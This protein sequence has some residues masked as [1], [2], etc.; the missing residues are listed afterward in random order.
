MQTVGHTALPVNMRQ[1]LT[2]ETVLEI[3]DIGTCGRA[4]LAILEIFTTPPHRTDTCCRGILD[5]A[6]TACR[7]GDTSLVSA[8]CE[9]LAEAFERCP[10]PLLTHL[11]PHLLDISTLAL[12]PPEP[13]AG[14]SHWQQA[15]I[16][17][18][19]VYVQSCADSVVR[20]GRSHLLG[21]LFAV[22]H[23]AKAATAPGLPE[24]HTHE[25]AAAHV[26]D[27]VAMV[28]RALLKAV[29]DEGAGAGGGR[30]AEGALSAHLQGMM[31]VYLEGV[32]GLLPLHQVIPG[33]S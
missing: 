1:R 9:T 17:L 19:V 8:A 10:D 18:F 15:L 13:A 23:M 7:D 16:A 22:S 29:E 2:S 11:Q 4:S 30:A 24:A 5:F 3:S 28:G 14:R 27:A 12:H 6:L 32:V 25:F 33:P 20:G 21:A 31:Q 26:V